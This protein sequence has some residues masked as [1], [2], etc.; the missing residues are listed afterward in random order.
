[1]KALPRRLLPLC[2]GMSLCLLSGCVSQKVDGDTTTFSFSLW[3]PLLSA[4]A[5]IGGAAWGWVNRDGESRY[6]WAGLILGP[7]ALVTIVPGLFLDR[8]VVT[9]QHFRL[10]TGF[11]FHPTRHEVQFQDVQRINLVVEES[12]GRRGRK[13]YNYYLD[14]YQRSGGMQHVPIGTL[15]QEGALEKVLEMAVQRGIPIADM[16][17]Q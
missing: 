10:N 4:V 3:V 13:N 12:R 2:V 5:C 8:A 11:W 9:P 14:C 6:P 15:M 1:V 7:I 16:T 17:G